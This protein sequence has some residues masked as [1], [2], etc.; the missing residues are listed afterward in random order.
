MKRWP[1]TV[2]MQIL[3]I[4]AL[5]I[6]TMLTI[7]ST[8]VV[9][10]NDELE[11][12]IASNTQQL[13]GKCKQSI[14]S[15]LEDMRRISMNTAYQE[16]VQKLL[17]M[18]SIMERVANVELNEQAR[19]A[20]INASM[21][22]DSITCIQLF[23]IHG[24]LVIESGSSLLNEEHNRT[25]RNP[26]E[27]NTF[28]RVY[29]DL[30]NPSWTNGKPPYFY[31]YVPVYSM[32]A[33]NL[34]ERV[35]LLSFCLMPNDI[36]VIL[37]DVSPS[38]NAELLLLD[39]AGRIIASSN[40]SGIGQ[41]DQRYLLDNTQLTRLELPREYMFSTEHIGQ[42]GWMIRAVI[43]RSDLEGELKGIGRLII[44]LC[45]CVAVVLSVLCAWLIR[46]INRP[47]HQLSVYVKKAPKEM[48]LKRLQFKTQN[49]FSSI[50]D[51]FN[52]MLDRLLKSNQDK[53]DMA[54]S[55]YEME[56]DQKQWELDAL[57]SQINPHFL[58]N[59]LEYIRGMAMYHEVPQLADTA[60][61]LA[62]LMRYS[63]KGAEQSTVG[64]EILCVEQY[65]TIIENRF[66]GRIQVNINCD[67][68]LYNL[69]VPK[70]LL[71][72]LLENAVLHGLESKIGNGAVNI[73]VRYVKH[74]ASVEYLI[75]DD[76]VG[77]EPCE[78]SDIL[79]QLSN[80]SGENRAGLGLYSIQRRI[81]LI[82]GDHPS[83]HFSIQSEVNCGTRVV[84][85]IPAEEQG[86]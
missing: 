61:A 17:L 9:Y 41:T 78:L 44:I 22:K 60:L 25:I 54:Q 38:S 79:D 71:Q 16:S 77:M 56:L 74:E 73:V 42:N 2:K 57:R 31:F 43:P 85:K 75:E 76:G 19:S 28:S 84:L 33:Y 30:P 3:F 51:S 12:N 82:Y 52:E 45:L 8:A 35:G 6:L 15:F 63:I 64:D 83:V 70:M 5:S 29:Y 48:L 14:E 27:Q 65:A 36:S 21:L 7:A 59:T 23:D 24:D 10:L 34:G 40:Q 72:P 18:D 39:E 37:K 68:S 1:K 32:E 62:R 13:M 47:I 55:M 67:E 20:L 69:R 49:E 46:E 86:G 26:I 80:H 11:R 58:Y 81:R 50:A 66:G 53:M 4:L